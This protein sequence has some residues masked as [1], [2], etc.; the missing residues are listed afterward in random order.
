[1]AKRFRV[2]ARSQATTIFRQGQRLGV[3]YLLDGRAIRLTFRTRYL[4][5]GFS[6]PV[7]GDMWM[8]AEGEAADVDEAIGVFSNAG[9]D[10]AAAISVVMNAAIAPLEGELAFE[11]TAGSRG[12]RS[13]N[14][15][16]RATAWP[17]ARGLWTTKR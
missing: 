7:A 16:L 5:R 6:V 15:L 9:R 10:I 3:N 17:S 4:D 11:V 8:D 14:A 12:D 1:M 13:C 2:A